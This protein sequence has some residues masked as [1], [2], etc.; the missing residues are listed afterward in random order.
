MSDIA[1]EFPHLVIRAS[2]GTGKTFRLAHRFLGLM[3][4]GQTPDNVLAATFARKAAGEIVDRI[5]LRL[6]EAIVE[7]KK[8]ADLAKHV[9]QPQLSRERCMQ[10]LRKLLARM[11]RL[12]IGTLDSFF[13][14]LAGHF[15]FELGLPLG[16]TIIETVDELRLRDEAIQAVLAGESITDATTLV[17]MLFKGETRRSVT[18]QIRE[19]VDNLY[20]VFRRTPADAWEQIPRRV[21]MR[22]EDFPDALGRLVTL[23][24][25][26]D[27]RFAKAH[28]QDVVRAQGKNWF[29]FLEKGIAAKVA[30]GS[31]KFYGKELEDEVLAA[32]QPL[33]DEA[34]AQL[35]NALANQT[36]ATRRLLEKY[37]AAV[38]RLKR[39]RRQLR[40][41]DVTYELAQ[42]LAVGDVSSLA[43]R[44]DAHVA[45]LLL[46]EFQD[47]SLA[48]WTV[49]RPFAEAVTNDPGPSSFF[50]V[51]D[52]KQ[53]IYGWRG[54]VSEIFDCIREQLPEVGVD[55]LSTSYRSSPTVIQTV[56]RIF[57]TIGE[58]AVLG[59]YRA[60]AQAWQQ[61]FQPHTTARDELAGYAQ[62]VVAPAA[63]DG[64]D[65][66]DVTLGFAADEIARLTREHPGRSVGVLVRR[67]KTVAKIMHLLRTKHQLQAS[68]EGGN[69]LTDSAA[70]Q[71][72]L[73][74]LKL[75]DHPQDTVARFHV[76]HSPLGPL[77]GLVEF[78]DHKMAQRVA[79][80]IRSQLL[81]EG[82]GRTLSRW[83]PAIAPLCDGREW[84]RLEQLLEMAYRFTDNATLRTDDFAA[85]VE[86]ER[87]EDPRAANVRVMTVHQSKGLQFDI[88]VLPELDASIKNMIP[89]VVV[90]QDR[91]VDPITT[92]CR[93]AGSEVRQMLPERLQKL[94]E[95][96]AD[97]I[98]HESLCVLY[99]AL[100]RAVHA[101][102]M[103]VAPADETPGKLKFST[104]VPTYATLL[105]AALAPDAARIPGEVLFETGSI[106]WDTSSAP[107]EPSDADEEQVE[108]I[109]V[110]LKPA[111]PSLRGLERQS[112]SQLQ[113][114]TTVDLAKR[115]TLDTESARRRGSL[116][117]AWFETVEWLDDG[118]PNDETLDRLAREH[119][120]LS[121]DLVQLRAEFRDM[122]RQSGVRE[123]LS[124]SGYAGAPSL[125]VWRERRFAVRD[126]GVLLQGAFDRVVLVRD[127]D[128]VL[129]AD[130]VDFKTDH[131]AD[132]AA[133]AETVAYYEPQLAA[134]RRAVA[135][136]LGLTADKITTRL[137]FVASGQVVAL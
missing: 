79:F 52:V 81:A 82:F 50:C 58:N 123:M 111:A 75:A 136:L 97:P 92:V 1:T 26:G 37:D 132:D 43:F 122:L 49:V 71:L 117:H 118:E 102:H 16:W 46:D 35:I 74:A 110:T 78:A 129:S 87:V 128:Q 19:L 88:V 48:Q 85:L 116:I 36:E 66:N 114:G 60:V 3:F 67:N 91:P 32:Y 11:H 107:E 13:I 65:A 2:A 106:D 22:E 103:I 29:E 10:L 70:V 27:K 41:D 115:L 7:P 126:E 38:R 47:T 15:S 93:Y 125:E 130:V 113:G 6:A 84:S 134:Y 40:F 68:E 14:Q 98:V 62:L 121:L 59:D 56:N 100:T 18:S 57:H 86:S 101:L 39:E 24:P 94:F 8:L 45:H 99:V 90:E 63:L 55:M 21:L 96:W 33:V 53:A 124:R 80:Q 28:E 31:H 112:P 104:K 72:V 23:P 42:G 120:G 69:P 133:L 20:E 44:L 64:Q 34:A 17:G 109:D 51:G 30:D 137:L 89:K 61:R 119:H 131:I 77:L 108:L 95:R 9:A 83:L 76:A 73:S 4:A 105:R 5:L 12:R 54:G 25:F 127:G 135:L